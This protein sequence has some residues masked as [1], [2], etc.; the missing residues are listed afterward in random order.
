M[1]EFSTDMHTTKNQIKVEK[2]HVRAREMAWLINWP[3]AFVVFSWSGNREIQLSRG[4][5][6]IALPQNECFLACTIFFFQKCEQ[7]ATSIIYS[8]N[9][10]L[11]KVLPLCQIS[12]N[13]LYQEMLYQDLSVITNHKSKSNDVASDG[14]SDDIQ[15]IQPIHFLW[16]LSYLTHFSF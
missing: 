6:S 1:N 7:K 5:R 16:F 10:V 3:L 11:E 14:P 4:I 12:Q 9:M 13:A 2:R 8:S 15:K